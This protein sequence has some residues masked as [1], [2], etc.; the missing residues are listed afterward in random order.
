MDQLAG[1]PAADAGD[2]ARQMYALFKEEQARAAVLARC[3][4]KRNITMALYIAGGYLAVFLLCRILDGG[5][6]EYSF[7]GWLFGT[8]PRQSS[9]LFGWL[10]SKGL[11]LYASLVSILP[12][13]L[14]KYRFSLTALGAFCLGLLLGEL[15]GPNPAGAAYGFGHYGWAI[16]GGIFL[17]S[18]PMG[19]A[20]EKLANQGLSLQNKKLRLW[21][22]AFGLGVCAILL[23]VCLNKSGGPI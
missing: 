15:L 2:A 14:G 18:I 19:I 10:I 7:L 6:G 22:A 20:L 9:Y 21:C 4:R 11:Y 17:F 23:Y 16:W 5:M 3:R 8:D 12:A 13:L 1:K